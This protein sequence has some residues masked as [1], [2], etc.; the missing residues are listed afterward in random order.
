M[1]R[2]IAL[3]ALVLA[4][5]MAMAQDLGT[6]G[7]TYPIAEPDMLAMLEKRARDFVDSPKY[8]EWKADIAEQGRKAFSEPPPVPMSNWPTHRRFTWDPSILVA[9]DIRNQEG[10]VVVE[11]GTRFNPL[12]VVSLAEPLVFFD[13]RDERQ[14]EW[15]KQRNAEKRSKLILTGGSWVE[16]SRQ[17]GVRVYFDAN[18]WMTEKIGITAVPAIARQAGSVFEIEE[19]VPCNSRDCSR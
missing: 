16:L 10:A 3:I 11:R 15:A 12:D 18:G 1:A 13:G 2:R 17:L 4:S 7:P 8:E 6:R 14:V 5:F 19:G 9:Q